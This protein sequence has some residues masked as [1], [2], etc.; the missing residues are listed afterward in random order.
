MMDDK[1]VDLLLSFTKPPLT[2]NDRFHWRKVH[3][4]RKQVEDEVAGLIEL[5]R[6]QGI[7]LEV[8]PGMRLA[9]ELHY[10]PRVRRVRDTDN[11]VATLKPVADAVARAGLVPDDTPEFMAKPEPVIHLRE[12]R[13]PVALWARLIPAPPLEPSEGLNS[14]ERPV[15]ASFAGTSNPSGQPRSKRKATDG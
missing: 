7:D 1:G 5:A 6:D 8:P 15:L 9:V 13:A 4:L 10:Q 11:L 3:S 12:D 14:S 2:L